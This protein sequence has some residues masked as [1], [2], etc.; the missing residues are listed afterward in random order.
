[1]LFFVRI[2]VCPNPYQGT[3]TYWTKVFRKN[4]KEKIF[5]AVQHY[6]LEKLLLSFLHKIFE[7][8]FYRYVTIYKKA[9]SICKISSES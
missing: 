4:K 2:F 6:F 5:K 3:V 1:M 7:Q 8:K 9:A